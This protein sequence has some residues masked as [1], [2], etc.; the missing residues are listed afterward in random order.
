MPLAVSGARRSASLPNVP[1]VQEEGIAGYDVTSWNAVFA[2]K[3]TPAEI[4]TLLNQKV[5]EAV[6]DPA[7][8]T[9]FAE[10][11]IEAAGSSPADLGDKLKSDIAKWNAVIDKAGVQR[12]TFR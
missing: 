1:T 6:A 10:L 9:R 12:Q 2:P 7:V 8:K 5:R 4:V 3:G 11:G